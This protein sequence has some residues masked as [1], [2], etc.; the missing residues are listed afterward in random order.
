[1]P[2]A[3]AAV[4][5]VLAAIL[6]AAPHGSVHAAGPQLADYEVGNYELGGEFSLTN[7]DGK[8]AALKEWRGKVVVVFF[9][10][11]FCPDVCPTT[12]VEMS[13]LVEKMGAQSA[14]VQPV[15]ITVDP[16]RDTPAR[17]K[18]YVGNFRG[19]IV[20]LTGSERELNQ[21]ARLYKTRFA[22]RTVDSAAK[23]L[24]DHTAFTYMLDPQGRVRYMFPGDAGTD[25]MVQGAKALLRK[26]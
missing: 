1:L 17:L 3:V 10:Y 13:R 20:G 2:A 8:I 12:M 7:Q 25:V 15:F 9:G 26:P 14:Q 22:K 23:Y 24:I 6:L 21:V 16:A 11:T 19:H 18:S 4:F 5:A